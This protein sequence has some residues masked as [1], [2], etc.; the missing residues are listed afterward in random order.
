MR[1]L[2]ERHVNAAVPRKGSTV[3]IQNEGKNR[4]A[5]KL[6]IVT[7]LIKGKDGVVRRA[8]AKATNGN[9][10]SNSTPLSP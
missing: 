5:W 8:K 3:I 9:V 7:D 6:G 1:S 4:T 10:E 2:R